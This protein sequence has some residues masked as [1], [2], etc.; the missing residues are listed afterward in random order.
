MSGL[1]WHAA[2]RRSSTSAIQTRAV[3]RVLAGNVGIIWRV[4]PDEVESVGRIGGR[5]IVAQGLHNV[6]EVSVFPA[7]QNVALQ[8]TLTV[9]FI[10]NAG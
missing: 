2:R 10:G 9:D 6:G 4:D 7:N 1:G 8:I 3:L 5:I